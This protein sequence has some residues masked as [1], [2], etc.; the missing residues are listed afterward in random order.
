MLMMKW[1][2]KVHLNYLVRQPMIMQNGL[3]AWEDVIGYLGIVTVVMNC[4]FMYWFR[5]QFIEIVQE[6]IIVLSFL[7]PES[8]NDERTTA[9]TTPA[10]D[11]SFAN[12]IINNASK[13]SA[14]KNKD[15]LDFL[16]VIILTEHIIMFTRYLMLS[17]IGDIP[18][19]VQKKQD[20]VNTQI[21]TM[22]HMYKEQK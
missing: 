15:M 3:G 19:W 16:I 17:L 14:L 22:T 2:R 12:G 9:V 1:E 8:I 13:I 5:V 10:F 18:A 21:E 20:T 4:M 7:L 11:T 6:H